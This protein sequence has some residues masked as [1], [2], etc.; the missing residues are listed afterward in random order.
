[1]DE[2]EEGF[3]DEKRKQELKAETVMELRSYF[4]KEYNIKDVYLISTKN[5]LREAFDF[6][7]LDKDSQM[8]IKNTRICQECPICFETYDTFGGDVKPMKAGCGHTCCEGCLTNW[9]Y[10]KGSDTCPHC[11]Q[12][13]EID[14]M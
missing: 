8:A 2:D 11:R 13:A 10:I 14:I 6:K 4:E 9:C 3:V 1:M 5:E 12:T 7:R